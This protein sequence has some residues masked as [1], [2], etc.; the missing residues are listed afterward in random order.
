MRLNESRCRQDKNFFS[1]H[2]RD[3]D[4]LKKARRTKERNA[5]GGTISHEKERMKNE[6]P[7]SAHADAHGGGGGAKREGKKRGG[8]LK[9]TSPSLNEGYKK[10]KQSGRPKGE[11][12]WKTGV[13]AQWMK[14]CEMARIRLHTPPSG[15]SRESSVEEEVE[16][17]ARFEFPFGPFRKMGG[18]GA[19]PLVRGGWADVG[20]LLGVGAL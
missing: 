11:T 5:W 8:I 19:G 10:A 2:L 17:E 9:S 20:F 1:Y 13:G 18:G 16:V 12:K 6:K 15:T 4:G 7:A 14:V 3:D